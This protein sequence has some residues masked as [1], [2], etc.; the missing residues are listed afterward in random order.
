MKK[1]GIAL[2]VTMEKNKFG[3]IAEFLTPSFHF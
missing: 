1:C 2:R 3:N